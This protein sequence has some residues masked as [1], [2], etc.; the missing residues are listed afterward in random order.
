[1]LPSPVTSY[2]GKFTLRN[3]DMNLYKARVLQDASMHDIPALIKYGNRVFD[4]LTNLID[5]TDHNSIQA[6]ET[7]SFLPENFQP[8]N[9]VAANFYL[10]YKPHNGLFSL[11]R[12]FYQL[13]PIPKLVTIL[14]SKSWR[15]VVLYN[16]GPNS[17]I[18]YKNVCNVGP[19]INEMAILR[20]LI[21]KKSRQ[22]EITEQGD[23]I[24]NIVGETIYV[25]SSDTVKVQTYKNDFPRKEVLW[26]RW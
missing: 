1:M 19:L 18:I 7:P 21:T 24:K 4:D 26:F 14:D 3:I 15:T 17:N 12:G 6:E 20:N 25:S 23:V 11:K 9:T 10:D 22:F 13:L 8:I 5:L 2:T 16:E